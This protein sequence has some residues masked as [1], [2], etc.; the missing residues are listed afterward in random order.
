MDLIK[1]IDDS[2][3]Q[4]EKGVSLKK[5]CIINFFEKKLNLEILEM[6]DVELDYISTKVKAQNPIIPGQEYFFEVDSNFSLSRFEAFSMVATL[7][8][9]VKKD[10]SYECQ[11][12][13]L[14]KDVFQRHD[15][16]LKR[17]L[18]QYLES[19]EKDAELEFILHLLKEKTK[20]YNSNYVEEVP[21]DKKSFKITL[22]NKKVT[23]V[24][25]FQ[26]SI[27]VG[28]H[29]GSYS[30][31][32]IQL[33]YRDIG[34]VEVEKKLNKIMKFVD[35][36]IKGDLIVSNFNFNP[37]V[38]YAKKNDVWMEFNSRAIVEQEVGSVLVGFIVGDILT[39]NSLHLEI[40]I[41]GNVI[42]LK[43]N[44]LMQEK[45]FGWQSVE[46]MIDTIS[47][48]TAAVVNGTENSKKN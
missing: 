13:F 5:Q 8:K 39:Y 9:V 17:D 1:L 36:F 19:K 27:Q 21:G 41:K 29:C 28:F 32:S 6:K 3:E 11:L 48:L 37:L 38:E 35:N 43:A 31:N 34:A 45:T 2:R 42:L 25:G 47:Q 7:V 23:F 10:V 16:I 24:A 22:E 26:N 12:D 15:A 18:N 30:V 40:K 33:V 44:Y 46:D 14:F 4:N 20:K